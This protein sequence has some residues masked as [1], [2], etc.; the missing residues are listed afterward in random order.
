MKKIPPEAMCS[1][2]CQAW[3][4]L[5]IDDGK[6]TYHYGK[7]NTWS[8]AASHQ[9]SEKMLEMAITEKERGLEV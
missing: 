8:A 4:V 3:L 9:V 2:A 1:K 6:A 7:C 5:L